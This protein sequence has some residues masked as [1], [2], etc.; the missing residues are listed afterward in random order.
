MQIYKVN[1]KLT[2]LYQ[3]DKSKANVNLVKFA[4]T[5]SRLAPCTN[6]LLYMHSLAQIE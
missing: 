5:F 6:V 3:S 4:Y 2:R 1:V